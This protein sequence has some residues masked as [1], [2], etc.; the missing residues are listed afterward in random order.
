MAL[1][2]NE[3]NSCGE[4]TRPRS[5]QILH[6]AETMCARTHSLESERG[7]RGPNM[8]IR[9]EI[10]ITRPCCA[11]QPWLT[12]VTVVARPMDPQVCTCPA[13]M[14]SRRRARRCAF[15]RDARRCCRQGCWSSCKFVGIVVVASGEAAA[16]AIHCRYRRETRVKRLR[17]VVTAFCAT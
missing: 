9:S 3:P 1:G 6:S 10:I 7:F 12:P 11:A 17:Q 4:G 16:V 8:V 13:M 14:R 15:W 2:L 5:L